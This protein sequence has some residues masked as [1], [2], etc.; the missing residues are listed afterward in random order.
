MDIERFE[1]YLKDE[2]GISLS[3][4]RIMTISK[5]NGLYYDSTMEKIYYTK[6]DFYNEL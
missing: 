1:E 2:Y 4:N 3:K 6:D 5:A